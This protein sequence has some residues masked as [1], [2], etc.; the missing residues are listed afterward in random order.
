MGKWRKRLSQATGEGVITPFFQGSV[1]F[2]VAPQVK[3]LIGEAFILTELQSGHVQDIQIQFS[4]P[5]LLQ[6][7]AHI[8]TNKLQLTL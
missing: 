5:L 4:W 2:T 8:G 1:A 3:K 6:I 7:A